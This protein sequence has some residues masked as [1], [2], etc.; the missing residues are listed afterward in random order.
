[1][2]RHVVQ[3]V[4]SD[5]F[6]GV[7]RY[8]CYVAAELMCRDWR[9]TVVGG[10]PRGM[11]RQLPEGVGF[12]PARTATEVARALVAVGH[13]TLIHAHMTAAE[14][15]AVLTRPMTRARVVCTR[16]FAG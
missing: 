13:P 3:A 1:M 7:E 5:G 11:A 15:P 8:I 10:D 12:R 2:R 6:A 16:H 4:R 9:V 14:L